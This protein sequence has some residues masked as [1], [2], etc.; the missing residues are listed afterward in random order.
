[1]RTS[2]EVS[3]EK[4]R[5]GFY[6]PPSL[7]QLC[8]DRVSQLV[9]STSELS[10]L[11]P[12]A[13][14]GAFIRGLAKHRLAG[15]I[16]TVTAIELLESEAAKCSAE[17]AVSG[18]D[19]RVLNTSAV[20]WAADRRD[21]HDLAVGNP[22]FVRF[23]FVPPDDRAASE[24]LGTALGISFRGVG[25]L[26]IP[27]FVGALAS[28]KPK[29]S[30]AFIIPAEFL[31]GISGAL[32]RDWLAQHVRRLRL[33][34][35]QPGSFPGVLQ[36]VVIVSGSI[37]GAGEQPSGILDVQEHLSSNESASWS[38][39]ISSDARTWTRYLLRREHADALDEAESLKAC[40]HLGDVARFEVATVTGA[41]DFFC[42]DDAT[43]TA[44]GLRP[45]ARPMLPRM[46]HAPGLTFDQGEHD[47][48]RDTD[49]R[50]W[51]LDFSDANPDPH[52]STSAVDYLKAG[53]ERALQTRYKC[54]IRD[55]WYRVPI[56]KPGELLMAKRSHVYPRVVVNSAA[57][58]TTDTVY[59]GRLLPTANVT[60]QDFAAVFHNSLT[61]LSAEVEGRSFGGGVLELVPS[62]VTR[63]R[64]P[65]AHEM[66][67]ELSRLD[68]ISRESGGGESDALIEETDAL[69]AKKTPGLSTDL[70]DQLRGAYAS[71]RMRRLAR[72]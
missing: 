19:G 21:L 29:G 65:R 59:R 47:L 33:D 72:T 23:Q 6:S 14:D 20:A 40:G 30:F 35:F 64:L 10:V 69:V 2:V 8:W 58:L 22:P 28:L 7:V 60:V 4:L 11:E 36:E 46:R 16:R 56:V 57:V 68:W 17:L 42:L 67:S 32:V 13:G 27:V 18:A 5:G 55:P 44:L 41:N 49:A 50:I 53:E 26:W 51:M 48:L 70:M 45:W 34:V 38:H 61:L 63:L 9:G 24:R 12:S 3:A 66:G 54:R 62:E 71:L 25:N 39:Q 1:M 52:V 37:V 15:Q 43:V 31:T